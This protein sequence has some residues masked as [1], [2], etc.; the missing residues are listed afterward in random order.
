MFYISADL[1]NLTA[2]KQTHRKIWGKRCRE[3]GRER[4]RKRGRKLI[5]VTR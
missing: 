4:E 1:Q 2:Q 5:S 3:R